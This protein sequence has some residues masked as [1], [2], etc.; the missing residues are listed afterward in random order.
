LLGLD[1]LSILEVADYGICP[2]KNLALAIEEP[3]TELSYPVSAIREFHPGL[4]IVILVID[5]IVHKLSDVS[6]SIGP[7]EL[8]EAVH[9]VIAPCTVVGPSI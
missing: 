4:C 3:S 7:S 6:A 2:V 5:F 8:S 1:E 9:V